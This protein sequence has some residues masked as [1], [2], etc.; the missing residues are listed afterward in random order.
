MIVNI[1]LK[2]TIK[3]R[4]YFTSDLHLNHF[5]II[6]YCGRPFETLKEMN[7]TII[8]NWNS[9]VK[10]ED[11][12]FHIGDFC[13][14]NS[15]GG[16]K[17]EGVPIKASILEGQLNGKI[18]HIRGNHDRNNST[19]TIITKLVIY[20]GR[21]AINL[22]HNPD[23]IDINYSINFVG[24]V[25]NNWEIKRIRRGEGFT[26]AINVGVDVHKFFPVTFEELMKKY[27]KWK[28]EMS[29]N[30]NKDDRKET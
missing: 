7:T 25:H 20:Y 12:V 26:D 5:N 23:Y 6:E 21:K 27:H 14:K 9:R 16:K 11:I 15:A 19:K 3:I 8:R 30:E 22:V 10:P 24:H 18:I 1:F 29:K 28:R 4:Y 17:G 2:E 13:F